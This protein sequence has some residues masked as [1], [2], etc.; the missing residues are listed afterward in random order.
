MKPAYAELRQ[1]VSYLGRLLGDTIIEQEGRRLF[2]LVERVRRLAKA[3]REGDQAAQEALLRLIEGLPLEDARGVVKAFASFFQLVNLAEDAERVR[4]A[5]RRLLQAAAEGTPMAETIAEAVQRLHAQG[6]TAQ[7][8]QGLLDQLL[9]MPVMT[10]HPTEAKRR[11]VLIKL[12]RISAE[13]HRLEYH[14]PTPAEEREAE[15]LIRE[16]IASLW[17]TEVTRT[18]KPT[19]LDEVRNGLYY[20]EHTLF[21]LVPRLY[22]DLQEALARYYPGVEFRIPQFLRFGSWIGGDCDGNPF[23]TPTVIEE[24]LRS[25]KALAIRLYQQ[26]IE[27]MYGLLSSDESYGISS[28]LWDSLDA[29][30]E[31]LPEEAAHYRQLYPRQPYRQKIALVYR[32]L[33]LTAEANQQPWRQYYVPRRGEYLNEDEFIADLTV[34]QESLRR[35]RGERMAAGRLGRLVTQA[36]VFGFH[37]A[38]LDIRQHS[39]RHTQALSEVFARYG[40][41]PNYAGLTEVE[42]SALLTAE[43]LNPRPLVPLWLDFSPA[44]NEVLEVFRVIRRAHQRVGPRAI[45]SYI[46]SMTSAPSDVLAVLL[47]AKEVG[48]DSRLG[49]V[50]L[51]ETLPDLEAAPSVMEALFANPA[52][53]RH[54]QTQSNHQ[55]I[56]VGYSDS[57]KDGGYLGANWALYRAHEALATACG[58]YGVTLTLF[59]GRG[60]TIGRGGGPAN[61]AILAQPA[62]AIRGRLKMTE[63]GEVVSERY[64]NPRVAHRH[65]EQIIHAVLLTG[66]APATYRPEQMQRWREIMNALSRIAETTYRQLVYGTPELVVYFQ[67]ATPIEEISELNIAS[68]PARRQASQ[69]IED[70][71]AIPWSFAWT[72]TR[73]NLPGW[74]GLGSA[75]QGWAGED[76]ERWRELQT[77]Y[78]E[79]PFLRATVDNAQMALRKADMQIASLY[80]RLTSPEV[81]AAIFPRLREEYERSVAAVLRLTG[82]DDLLADEPWLQRAIRLRNPYIDPLN[83]AQVALLMR[84]RENGEPAEEDILQRTVRM[85]INGIAAGLRNT[86]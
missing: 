68:R 76:E 43:L 48:V 85:T 69:R 17:Q 11:T 53:H 42:R 78:R 62:N 81:A 23:V 86:G 31:L 83:Y 66:G 59:H 63:Q 56:M 16:E 25:H 5:H 74:Y 35:H 12:A 47:L 4:V 72:Q 73:V 28:D 79:W 71:R 33:Q 10:A 70:L 6:M 40:M 26:A 80:T 19:V 67:T 77:M 34:M 2:D 39:R 57:N 41:V 18:R 15:A 13:L 75:L 84:L 64:S 46:V 44:T 65:L 27:R 60:G 1:Q 30:A 20:F 37:L 58:R 38:T 8:V 54:L 21:D 14:S 32:K 55:Q 51:F 61:R 82:H 49:V 29:D 45:K 7:E 36:R 3:G 24:T 9:V 22:M 52:Y 50:P